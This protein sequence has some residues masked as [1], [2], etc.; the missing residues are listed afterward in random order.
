MIFLRRNISIRL[1]VRK[2][3]SLWT[4]RKKLRLQCPVLFLQFPHL[5]LQRLV[6]AFLVRFGI[7]F[8]IFFQW[9]YFQIQ[10][11][12][13]LLKIIYN[14]LLHPISVIRWLHKLCWLNLLITFFSQSFN[15]LLKIH[16]FLLIFVNIFLVNFF[17]G[18]NLI[19]K[20]PSLR[21]DFFL[22]LFVFIL[23]KNDFL[24]GFE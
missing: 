1:F 9:S 17:L 24:F 13:F 7:E 15:F 14:L 6:I 2:L 22:K 20:I 4:L 3:R 8:N 18:S 19:F 12:V 11:L 21:K 5:H 10:G 23:K 16:D